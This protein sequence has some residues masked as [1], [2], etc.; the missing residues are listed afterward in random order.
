M[1]RARLRPGDEAG[2]QLSGWAVRMAG[3]DRRRVHGAGIGP[4]VRCLPQRTLPRQSLAAAAPVEREGAVMSRSIPVRTDNFRVDIDGDGIA[5]LIFQ[6]AG[7]MPVTD[8]QGHAELA[9]IWPQLA[10]LPQ[11]RAVLIRSEGRAFCAGGDLA[12]VQDMLDSDSARKRVLREARDLVRG[13]IDCDKPIVSAI[14]GAA[15]G[16]GLAAA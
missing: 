3:G 1:R 5:H 12:M 14:H 11:V 13:M 8:A 4:S 2:H 10:A 16:A 6:P 15:V 9:A 7:G